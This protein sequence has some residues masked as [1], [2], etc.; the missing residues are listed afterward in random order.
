MGLD[1]TLPAQVVDESVER[2]AVDRSLLEEVVDSIFAG[3]NFQHMSIGQ[4]SKQTRSQSTDTAGHNRLDSKQAMD[5]LG[6]ESR[7]ESDAV[8]HFGDVSVDLSIDPSCD[9]T[10]YTQAGAIRRLVMNLLG[11]SLKYTAKGSIKVSLTQD[12]IRDECTPPRRACKRVDDL[13]MAAFY[14]RKQ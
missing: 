5:Q 8:A 12:Q 10:F 6:L 4:L 2:G 11:N 7:N 3:F 13:E 9:W 14:R 1:E